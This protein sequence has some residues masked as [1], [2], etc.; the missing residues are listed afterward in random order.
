M[1]N[2][3]V[4][5][6]IQQDAI[7]KISEL[8]QENMKDSI[9]EAVKD[10]FQ[11]EVTEK[12]IDYIRDD[13]DISDSINSWMDY[14]F[15]I[16]DYLRNVDLNDFI[17]GSDTESEIQKL[18]EQYSPVSNCTTADLATKAI[19]KAVRYL[20]LKDDEFVEDIEDA[21]ARRKQKDLIAEM[22]ESIIE[23][24]KDAVRSELRTEFINELNEY[25]AAVENAKKLLN[26]ETSVTVPL[27]LV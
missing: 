1:E 11:D 7:E 18:L 13:Y 26:T 15:D 17:D 10:D 24:T 5:L 8:V 16:E 14:H 20:L 9:V 3:N 22:R 2:I 23:E 12:V 25:S 19:R 27:D 6:G 21:I 4:T